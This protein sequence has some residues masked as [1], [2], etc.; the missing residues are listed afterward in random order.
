MIVGSKFCIMG[1]G[2]KT[3]GRDPHISY[4]VEDTSDTDSETQSTS[5]HG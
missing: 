3:N 1:I 4:D 2:K 5:E